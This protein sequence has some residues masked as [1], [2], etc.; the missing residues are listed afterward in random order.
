MTP[1]AHAKTQT[2]ELEIRDRGRDGWRLIVRSQRYHRELTVPH[3]TRS[4]RGGIEAG[5]ELVLA[6]IERTAGA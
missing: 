4:G 1:S 5:L 2:F 3:R 6:E